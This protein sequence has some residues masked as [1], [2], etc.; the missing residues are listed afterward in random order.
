[1]DFLALKKNLRKDYSGF[2]PYKLGLLSDAAPQYLAQALRGSSFDF[3]IDLQL[4]EA[5]IGL[6]EQEINIQSGL[7]NFGPDG[8]FYYHSLQVLKSKFYKTELS[9]RHNFG[10]DFIKSFKSNLDFFIKNKVAHVF[11]NLF[12]TEPDLIFG[13]GGFQNEN[14]FAFQ[15][16]QINAGLA[17]LASQNSGL[18]LIALPANHFDSTFYYSSQAD[19][20]FETLPILANSFL[21]LL[22]SRLGTMKKCIVL[23]LDNTI[24]GGIVGDDGWENIEIGNLGRG[25]VFS[26]IQFWLKELKNRGVLLVVCSKNEVA[27]AKEPFLKNPD[28]VLKL[29]DFALFVANWLPKTE[30]I[31]EIVSALNIGID[32]LVFLDD[33]P[34]EREL[35][36]N[37]FPDISVPDLPNDPSQWLVFLQKESLFESS[38]WTVE[39]V[40]RTKLYQIVTKRKSEQTSHAS[41]DDYLESLQMKA[42]VSL[43]D[44][45][46]LPRV[47]QLL[48]RTNQFNLRNVRHSEAE[49]SQMLDSG[50]YI[51]FAIGLEDKFGDEGI[52]SALIV[53][54]EANSFIIDSW[55]MSCR[56]FSR[57]L[58]CLVFNAL[59]EEAK[60][61]NSVIIA[62]Y[63]ES[64]KNQMLKKLLPTLGFASFEK[65]FRLDIQDQ[66]MQKHYISVVKN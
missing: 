13:Q 33:N 62:E 59:I 3:K 5:G 52:V 28:M 65:G 50:N 2:R 11:S 21:K 51:G 54:K 19:I 16:I 17:K 42:K 12:H 48:Q 53:K 20:S 44:A 61:D 7:M 40:K 8:V 9:Q 23:D 46:S 55:V 15:L 36:K 27:N 35:V 39:D 34:A 66:K 47:A 6:A 29:D 38:G 37:V 22:Q 1:M 10:E 64:A 56:V 26:D 24:W 60:K 4:F 43:I 49:L 63:V 41:L 57:G 30:N 58:E 25:K 45:F 31:N 14:S 32:S 18:V